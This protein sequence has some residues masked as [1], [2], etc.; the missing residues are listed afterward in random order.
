VIGFIDLGNIRFEANVSIR[1]KLRI[2]AISILGNTLLFIAP[3]GLS[4]EINNGI[5][6]TAV[7]LFYV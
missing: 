6:D 1:E 2:D 4:N 5:Q 7:L 3:S